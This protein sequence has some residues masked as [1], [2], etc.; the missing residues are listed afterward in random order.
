MKPAKSFHVSLEE[1][2][3]QLSYNPDSGEL[4]W[5]INKKGPVKAGDQ[6]GSMMATGY[7]VV[8]INGKEYLAHRIAW[9]M[10]YGIDPVETQID[11]DDMDRSNNAIKNLRLANDSQNRANTKARSHNKI[12]VKGVSQKRGS[13]KFI[14]RITI[15]SVGIHL[16][17]FSTVEEAHAAYCKAAEKR[18]GEFFN[19]G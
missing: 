16:G 12:G 19:A 2:N 4:R 13:T 10:H 14:A 5:K 1:I 15:N 3:R 7:R 11:H 18:H 17:E 8:G 9:F 6:A